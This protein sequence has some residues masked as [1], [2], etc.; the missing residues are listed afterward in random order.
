M[1]LSNFIDA[2]HVF[3]DSIP[4]GIDP[5]I[6]IS[7][8]KTYGLCIK[9][10]YESNGVHYTFQIKPTDTGMVQVSTSV[11]ERIDKR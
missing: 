9:T 10:Q 8:S 4:K 6:Y 5:D 7:S 11:V 1:V 3:R 2:L